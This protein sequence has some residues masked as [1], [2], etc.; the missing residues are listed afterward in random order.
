M[1]P[2]K[3]VCVED[4]KNMLWT[5]DEV[6]LLLETVISFKSRKSYEGIDWESVKEKYETIKNDFLKAFPSENKPGFHGKLLFTREKVAAKVKQMRVSYRKALDSGKQSGGGRVVATFFDF[7][8]QIWITRSGSPATESMNN[9]LDGT[10]DS[11]DAQSHSFESSTENAT[12]QSR[13]STPQVTCKN[14]R[15]DECNEDEDIESS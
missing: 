12:F 15:S 1:P 2:K 14:D 4:S 9:G 6:Q 8:N 13:S 7:C 5:D 11:T 10:V 3:K